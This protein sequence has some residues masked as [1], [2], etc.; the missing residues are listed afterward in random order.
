MIRFYA[1][2]FLF[3]VLSR[4]AGTGNAIQR[5]FGIYGIIVC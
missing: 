3:V 1:A 4:Q 2:F 5:G